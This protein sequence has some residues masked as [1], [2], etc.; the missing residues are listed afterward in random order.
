MK[1]EEAAEEVKTLS[2]SLIPTSLAQHIDGQKH[3]QL[4]LLRAVLEAQQSKILIWTIPSGF[5]SRYCSR[6]RRDCVSCGQGIKTRAFSK[7]VFSFPCCASCHTS[8]RGLLSD[9]HQTLQ[10]PFRLLLPRSL[11]SLGHRP[12]F[13]VNSVS[14]RSWPRLLKDNKEK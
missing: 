8:S 9:C 13:H 12:L 3:S 10:Q 11:L 14:V 4:A 1:G 6:S 7:T 5:S 2:Q